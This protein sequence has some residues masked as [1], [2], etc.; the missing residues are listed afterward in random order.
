MAF[1]A[2]A[3]RWPDAL[4][5]QLV[6]YGL[7]DPDS[8][9]LSPLFLIS[10]AL[11]IVILTTVLTYSFHRTPAGITAQ[12]VLIGAQHQSSDSHSGSARRG[13]R[14]RQPLSTALVG[15]QGS[16]KTALYSTLLYGTTPSTQTSQQ[17]SSVQLVLSDEESGAK[18]SVHLHDL[19][20]HPRLRPLAK[21]VQIV[22]G[23]DV[24]LFCID[25]VGALSAGAG[26]ATSTIGQDSF[27]AAVDYLHSTLMSLAR[28]RLALSKAKGV[29][30]IPPAFAILLTR[31]DLSPLLAS[32]A[33]SKDT[34][35]AG[36]D[37]AAALVARQ[38]RQQAASAVLL[39]RART[40]LETEL[41]KRR[42]ADVDLA[43]S[44]KQQSQTAPGVAKA[45]AKIGGMGEVARG[46][47]EGSGSGLAGQVLS[48][49]GLGGLLGNGRSRGKG[50]LVEDDDDGGHDG[51]GGQDDLDVPDYYL[52]SAAGGGLSTFSFEKMDPEVVFDGQI[53]ILLSTVGRERGW[54]KGANAASGGFDG[55][56]ELKRWVID[57]VQ[58]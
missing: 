46:E 34:K 41:R 45:K 40:S 23:A 52:G 10:T 27:G 25:T 44:G 38:K 11:G 2:S 54:E 56:A 22:A 39:S 37:E 51:L 58:A 28:Q 50:G 20:G 3:V 29:N 12:P 24:I 7:I 14:R 53:P 5:S 19:P 35:D 6:S 30:P 17:S 57:Q 36:V 21:H 13:A 49:F 9:Q 26:T 18:A 47:G 55:L 1:L 32:S 16:G 8:S 43:T 33:T 31:A 4:Q 15:A 48:L 42:A